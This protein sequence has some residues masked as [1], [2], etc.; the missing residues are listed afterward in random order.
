MVARLFRG[1][2]AAR[3]TLPVPGI[4]SELELQT[5]ESV[6]VIGA[7]RVGSAI[8]ARLRERGVAVGGDGAELVLLCV[9]DGAIAAVAGTVDSGP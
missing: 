6:Q 3:S 1:R 7:G 2:R 8:A 5:F 9:P 4:H